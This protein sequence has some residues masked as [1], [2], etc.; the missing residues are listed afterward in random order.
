MSTTNKPDP[1]GDPTA[2]EGLDPAA[3]VGR[4]PERQAATIPGGV[5]SK[6]ERI[7]AGD[8]QPGPTVN[9]DDASLG[10]GQSR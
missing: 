10:E 4:L 3:F 7:A 8:T 1:T 2:T 5:S 6:D 9:D